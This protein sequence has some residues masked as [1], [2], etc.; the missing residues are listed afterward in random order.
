MEKNPV[1]RLSQIRCYTGLALVLAGLAIVGLVGTPFVLQYHH[2]SDVHENQS[3]AICVMAFAHVTPPS[4]PQALDPPPIT[5]TL[6]ITAVEIP[7]ST[8]DVRTP[9]VRGPPRV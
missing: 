4:A 2:H 5:V 7:A 8:F 3:C 6:V 1:P 9:S